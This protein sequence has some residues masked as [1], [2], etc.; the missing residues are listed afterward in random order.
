MKIDKSMDYKI[1]EN[2]RHLREIFSPLTEQM[3]AEGLS[4]VVLA[5][6]KEFV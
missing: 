5:E 6:I 4:K 3:N 1:S 2:L